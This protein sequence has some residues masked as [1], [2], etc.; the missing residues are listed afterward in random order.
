M[1]SGQTDWAGDPRLIT[2]SIIYLLGPARHPV[3]TLSFE[4]RV[5]NL[6]VDVGSWPWWL[7]SQIDQ[8]ALL[9]CDEKKPQSA[10]VLLFCVLFQ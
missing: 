9:R 8:F 3:I 1:N 6:R 2:I 10:A 4:L 5:Y 7:S